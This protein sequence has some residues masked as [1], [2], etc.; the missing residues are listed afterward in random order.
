MLSMVLQN[1]RIR[2]VGRMVGSDLRQLQELVQSSIPFS[3]ALDLANFAKECHV[4]PNAKCS[5]TDL[6]AVILGKRLNKNVSER[7]SMAW[8]NL[9]LSAE[10]VQY[11][12]C[13][14][15]VALLMYLALSKISAPKP[16]PTADLD[17]MDPVLLYNTDNTTI[18]ASGHL[19]P[20]LGATSFDGINITPTCTLVEITDI[21]VPAA[22]MVNG[23]SSHLDQLLS[24]LYVYAVI[25]VYSTLQISIY[26]CSSNY[27]QQ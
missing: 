7:K 21:L 9:A 13:D 16:L 5:L 18:V 27:N 4:I 23:V 12:A 15:Y 10:Q 6:C 14:A 26:L 3:G 25:S 8:E 22:L 11:A 20:N 17:P 24:A 1:P 2:K 19:S